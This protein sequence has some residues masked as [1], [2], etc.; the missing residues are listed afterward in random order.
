MKAE[1]D[2]TAVR[3]SCTITAETPLEVEAI[4]FVGAVAFH[5]WGGGTP[6]QYT[7]WGGHLYT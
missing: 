5:S 2:A 6:E 4:E 7:A 1:E 3:Y